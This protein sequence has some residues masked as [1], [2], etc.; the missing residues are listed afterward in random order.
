M[1]IAEFTLGFPRAVNGDPEP[2]VARELQ[3]ALG[4]GANSPHPVCDPREAPGLGSGVRTAPARTETLEALA[5]VHS[6]Q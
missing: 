2:G 6:L 5:S 3:V 4:E 1:P